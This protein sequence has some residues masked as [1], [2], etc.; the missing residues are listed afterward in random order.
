LEFK[1]LATLSDKEGRYIILDIV[2]KSIQICLIN[3]YAPNVQQGGVTFLYKIMQNLKSKY[4]ENVII[5]GGDFNI[6][7]D[8]KGK[9]IERSK[10]K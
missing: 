4:N 10:Y 1:I 7:L 9:K 2:I 5:L 3:I 8:K 6:N